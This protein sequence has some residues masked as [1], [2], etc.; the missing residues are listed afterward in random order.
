VAAIKGYSVD[1]LDDNIVELKVWG[2]WVR[3]DGEAYVQHF[4]NKVTPLKGSK[5]WVIADISEFPPQVPEVTDQIQE[6]MRIAGE[7]GMQKAANLVS[8][9]MTKL[10]IRRLS[11]ESG[12]DEFSF[13]QD[14]AEALQ[15]L[16]S[17]GGGGK[18][19]R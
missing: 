16:R 5:W 18:A 7:Y 14:R 13:F 6:T 9:A 4:K 1:V 15:W 19:G 8:S 12:I 11:K 10:Q 17:V 3:E 2:L